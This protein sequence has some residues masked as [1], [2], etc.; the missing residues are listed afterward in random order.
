MLGA[1]IHG[2][3]FFNEK[4]FPFENTDSL[5]TRKRQRLRH[6][7]CARILE[8]PISIRA[9]VVDTG[10]CD[11][12]NFFFE[13]LGD[14]IAWLEADGEIVKVILSGHGHRLVVDFLIDLLELTRGH[15]YD[16][17][18]HGDARGVLVADDAQLGGGGL[19]RDG[20]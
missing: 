5:I 20:R 8:H 1:F 10:H 15:L 13:L 19:L 7:R 4:R 17:G 9:H 18:M 16:A 2:V 12:I 6:R 14:R 11:Y 3:Q